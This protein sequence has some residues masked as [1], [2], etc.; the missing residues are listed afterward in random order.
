[1]FHFAKEV[2]LFF[3]LLIPCWVLIFAWQRRQRKNLLRQFAD[4][5]LITQLS[6]SMSEWKPLLKFVILMLAYTFAV[7]A[8][9]QPEFGSRLQETK[10][11]GGEI[12]IL[13]DV[14][15]SMMAQDIQ[16]SRLERSKQAVSRL[17]DRLQEDK[18]GLIVFAGESYVQLP[19]TADYVSAKMFLSTITPDI[20]P[21][22]GTA[23][24]EAIRNG[25]RSFSPVQE[26]G[27]AIIILT[28]GENH[29]DDAVAYAKEA[30]SKGIAVHTIGV[31][32]SQGA[33]IP[34]PGGDAN[35]F[36]RDK[37]NQIVISKLDE[38]M[39]K[40]IAEAGNG[41]YVRASNAQLG[42][43]T[44]FDEMNKMERT[45]YESKVYSDFDNV[46]QWPLGVALLLLILEAMTGYRRWNLGWIESLKLKLKLK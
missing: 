20:V 26:S 19:V 10:R 4:P 1:M 43:N 39:L 35:Q 11:K 17:V 13:L 18:I 12:M 36:L 44:I 30:V 23:I 37:E 33:P 14:S 46:Y 9:A 38:P 6:P 16:P 31:G 3:L 45:E 32:L 8:L 2:Y 27:K 41:M 22:Q 25:I 15:N 40:S 34:L 7:L 28:D 21:V 42:L 5:A 24:G 29:E